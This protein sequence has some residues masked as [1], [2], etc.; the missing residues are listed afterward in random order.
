MSQ[1]HW[2]GIG[3][4]SELVDY[5]RILGHLEGDRFIVTVQATEAKSGRLIDLYPFTLEISEQRITVS[6]RDD[7]ESGA[8]VQLTNPK[9]SRR[10]GRFDI[11]FTC[12]SSQQQWTLM[13]N[14]GIVR[15]AVPHCL[16]DT[17]GRLRIG[18]GGGEA[19]IN[20]VSM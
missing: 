5:G 7:Q 15:S 20:I 9:K 11:I 6:W 19:V 2:R 13:V 8:S 12:E 18:G 16:E 14:G 4:G 3:V 10:N 17:R 1:I